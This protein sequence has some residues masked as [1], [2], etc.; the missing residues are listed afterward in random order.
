MDRRAGF[1]RSA[2]R[3]SSEAGP[4]ARGIRSAANERVYSFVSFLVQIH[5]L[6]NDYVGMI[7][8]R[9]SKPPTLW[10][11]TALAPSRSNIEP[12]DTPFR[13]GVDKTTLRQTWLVSISRKREKIFFV[14]RT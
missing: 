13:S 4:A 5:C 3:L 2:W 12:G 11:V 9:I 10:N 7:S 6:A 1:F 14:T 8:I